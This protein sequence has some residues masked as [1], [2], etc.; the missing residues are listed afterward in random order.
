MSCVHE[1]SPEIATTC[2]NFMKNGFIQ[3]NKLN[4]LSTAFPIDTHFVYT[5]KTQ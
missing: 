5:S 3:S 2:T 4:W 1:K